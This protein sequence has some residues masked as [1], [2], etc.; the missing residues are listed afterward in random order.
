[1]RRKDVQEVWEVEH[2]ITKYEENGIKYAESWIQINLPY[3]KRGEQLKFIYRIEIG[4]L[5]GIH[6]HLIVNRLWGTDLLIAK[7][8][9]HKVNFQILYAEGDFRKLASY[10]TKPLPEEVGQMSFV[11]DTDRKKLKAYVPSRNLIKPEPQI[12][13]TR[14]RTVRK[15]VEDGPK[16]TP[17]YYIDP[18]SVEYGVNPYTGYSYYRWRERILRTQER[19]QV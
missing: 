18:D 11:E 8:W 7:C 9:K 4:R 13:E 5:G 15:F 6:I 1:M 16:A 19:Q 3:K 10:I 17:G 14:R 12:T 2:Y